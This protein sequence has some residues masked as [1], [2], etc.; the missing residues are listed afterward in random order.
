MVVTNEQCLDVV[1][2]A[3]LRSLG[4]SARSFRGLGAVR[5]R[6]HPGDR[7]WGHVRGDP[8]LLGEAEAQGRKEQPRRTDPGNTR[9]Q[10]RFL[11][12]APERFNLHGKEGVD[13]SSPSEGF[14]KFLL[15]RPF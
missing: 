6:Q 12:F 4:L 11:R 3:K 7:S 2:Q 15:I 1:E 14:A 10:A 9:R 5:P 8:G 13:G